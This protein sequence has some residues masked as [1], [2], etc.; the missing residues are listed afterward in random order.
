MQT[1]PVNTTASAISYVAPITKNTNS[2]STEVAFLPTSLLAIIAIL[3]GAIGYFIKKILD[4][5]EKISEDVGDI[6]PKV[7]ILWEM[8]FASSNS[9]LVLNP[10]GIEILNSS[11][12]KKIIDDN[13]ERLIIEIKERMPSNA[14]Q[15]QECS[16]KVMS[17]F[18]SESATL[19]KLQE[20]A[21]STGVDVDTVLFAGSLYLRDLALPKFDCK[22][23]DVDKRDVIEQ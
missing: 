14:Y 20:G 9:P 19:T 10:R 23:E 8:Q 21:Y 11:G 15:V 17:I 7:K 6:K 3:L 18:K 16:R 1:M 22:L 13:L 5:T 12:I 4:K 2:Q